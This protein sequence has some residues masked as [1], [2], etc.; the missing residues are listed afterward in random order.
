MVMYIKGGRGIRHGDPVSPLIFVLLIEYF[1]RNMA[2]V[3]ELLDFRFHPMCKNLKI[4]HLC[5]ADDLM[6]FCK[7]NEPSL[8]RIKQALKHFYEVSGPGE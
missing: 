5:F 4:N 2:M 7:A 6:H 8:T 1:S 3:G